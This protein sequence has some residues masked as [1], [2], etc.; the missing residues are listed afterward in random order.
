MERHDV[1]SLDSGSP[2]LDIWLRE[3]AAGAEARR[4]ARTFVWVGSQRV[5]QVLGYYSLAGHRL[6]RSTLPSSV[7]HGSPSEIPAILLARLALD[8]R[9]QGRGMG[10]ALLA[11]ALT[12]IAIA[13][14]TVAARFVVVDARD[15]RAATF[16]EHFG[17]RR[18]PDSLR[19]VQKVSDIEALIPGE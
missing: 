6:V 9:L 14:R 1:D 12:R 2:E 18:I 4:V 17:F 7:G 5:D 11:D 15:D 3:Q 10:A 19:L 16:Y 8:A 13:T